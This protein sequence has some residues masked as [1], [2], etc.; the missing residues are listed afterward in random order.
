MRSY[1]YYYYN[2]FSSS[3]AVFF[4]FFFFLTTTASASSKASF[5]IH[6]FVGVPVVKT[7]TKTTNSYSSPRCRFLKLSPSPSP[8]LSPSPS[9]S[10]SYYAASHHHHL[11]MVTTS[12]TLGGGKGHHHHHLSEIDELCI[13]NAARYCLDNNDND[14]ATNDSSNN[15]NECDLDEYDALV[16]TLQQQREYHLYH[17]RTINDLLLKLSLLLSD[18]DVKTTGRIPQRQRH[19][20]EQDEKQLEDY[21]AEYLS[22]QER[23]DYD[24]TD[25]NDDDGDDDKEDIIDMES[26]VVT[27]QE[28]DQYHLEHVE[29]INDLLSRLNVVVD[30]T[31]TTHNVNAA[32]GATRSNDVNGLTA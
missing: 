25:E 2:N 31:T 17:T 20:N 6:A 32:A 16:M 26:L 23:N 4:V 21:V 19:L 28:Q 18:D 27:L 15:N 3:F 12:S 10:S 29:T 13:E 5:F 24:T 22:L 7:P 8:S 11:M 14:L 1:Y 30:T 9:P